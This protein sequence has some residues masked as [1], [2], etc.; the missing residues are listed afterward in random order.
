[1]YL[2]TFVCVYGSIYIYTHK[3]ISKSTC[4]NMYKYMHIYVWIRICKKMN[5][6][7]YLY[8]DEIIV[9]AMYIDTNQYVYMIRFTK[10]LVNV[11]V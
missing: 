4:A 5:L 7:V 10:Q 2:S 11:D 8:Q 9:K 3:I 6:S 1:M